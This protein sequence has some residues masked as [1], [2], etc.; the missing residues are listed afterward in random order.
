VVGDE[1]HRADHHVVDARLGEGVEVIEDVRP[2]PRLARRG[3]ALEG[4]APV[5]DAGAVGDQAA[6][7]EQGV[8]VGVPRVEDPGRQRVGGEDDV[9]GRAADGVDPAREQGDEPGVGPPLPDEAASKSP[10]YFA[11]ESDD[12]CG[13]RTR[14]TRAS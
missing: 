12:Q 7:L 13:A 5:V 6:R 14:P 10:S 1:A 3:L 11:M 8:P 9:R 4:E 2:E